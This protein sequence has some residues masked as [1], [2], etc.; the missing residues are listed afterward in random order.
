MPGTWLQQPRPAPRGPA[1]HRRY[2]PATIQPG[3]VAA[4]VSGSEIYHVAVNVTP[5]PAARWKTMCGQCAGGIDSLVELLQGRFSQAVMQHLCWQGTGLFPT[6][7]DEHAL[8]AHAGIGVPLVKKGPA[9]L[10]VLAGENLA[11][12]FGVDLAP[13]A[14]EGATAMSAPKRREAKKSNT[15]KTVQPKQPPA[16]ERGAPVPPAARMRAAQRKAVSERMKRYWAERRQQTA[17]GR[18]TKQG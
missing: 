8:I 9:A 11:A 10:K 3:K 16:V 2:R 5:V 14:A 13:E 4:L 12:V 7:V 6:Q 15:P 18:K 17:V 1:S